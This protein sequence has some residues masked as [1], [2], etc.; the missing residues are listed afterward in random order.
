MAYGKSKNVDFYVITWNIFVN[1]TDGEYGIT[2]KIDH[3][4][5][6]DYFRKSVKQIFFVSQLGG[7]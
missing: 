3:P 5:T 4:I 6:R 2:D 1:A 7:N